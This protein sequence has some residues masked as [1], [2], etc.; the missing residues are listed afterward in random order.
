M[1]VKHLNAFSAA[2]ALLV[3]LGGSAAVSC[4]FPLPAAAYQTVQ[5]GALTFE[6]HAGDASLLQCDPSAE[7]A[8]IPSEIDGLPVTEIT[9]KACYQCA[10][11]KEIVIP[12]TVTK[13]GYRSFEGCTG[14][15]ALTVPDSVTVIGDYAF[16]GC[17]GLTAVRIGSGAATIRGSAF[18]ECIALK[19]IRLPDALKTISNN[20]FEGCSSLKSIKLPS[21]LGFIA[22]Y[23]FYNCSSLT[24]IVIPAGTSAIR[25]CA[26]CGCT[27]LKTVTVPESVQT[28]ESAVFKDCPDLT[29]RCAEGSAAYQHAVERRIPVEIIDFTQFVPSGLFG[30]TDGDG[31]IT[32]YDATLVLIASSELAA[33]FASD[34]LTLTAEQQVIADVDLDG[35][36]TPYD[37]AMILTFSSLLGAGFDDITWYELIGNPDLPDAP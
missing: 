35:G 16:Y 11:L 29:I 13:I 15:T 1:P 12:D 34:E 18:A 28:I 24:D 17:S 20:L 5:V 30:D 27:A 31:Q 9:D 10:A 7:S 14:L 32:P 37:A 26:F 23:A 19:Q 33:G 25:I 22:S 8:V 36:I 21:G 6:K 2:A 4:G 3:S